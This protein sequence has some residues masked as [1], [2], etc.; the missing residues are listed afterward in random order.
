LWLITADV[1]Q[2]RCDQFRNEISK[3]TWIKAPFYYPWI[4]RRTPM[5]LARSA[6]ND[7]IARLTWEKKERGHHLAWIQL[8]EK[9][10]DVCRKVSF[11]F[12]NP[13]R[14][15]PRVISGYVKPSYP[16]DIIRITLFMLSFIRTLLRRGR[17]RRLS[18]MDGRGRKVRE[19][20]GQREESHG[21]KRE[22]MPAPSSI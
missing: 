19:Q 22:A 2:Y 13:Q 6:R 5:P 11:P 15:H 1:N 21:M 7:K 3:A 14:M 4:A 12:I 18:E 10:L 9:M 16:P 8:S 17:W 20:E